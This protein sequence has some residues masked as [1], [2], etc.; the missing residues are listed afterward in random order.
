MRSRDEPTR[1]HRAATAG[2]GAGGPTDRERSDACIVLSLAAAQVALGSVGGLAAALEFVAGRRVGEVGL[3]DL[4]LSVTRGL[5]C[6]PGAGAAAQ[7]C[8]AQGCLF[9]CSVDQGAGS[10]RSRAA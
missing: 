3:P 5:L 9:A 7:G 6:C 10:A 1:R 2:N 4:G 8:F